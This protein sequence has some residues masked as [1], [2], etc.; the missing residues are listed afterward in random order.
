MMEFIRDYTYC[1]VCANRATAL[2]YVL[3]VLAL[4]LLPVPGH[5]WFLVLE[6]AF[7]LLGVTAFGLQTVSYYRRIRDLLSR[8]EGARSSKLT[9]SLKMR[10]AESSYCTRVAYRL[11]VNEH[12]KRVL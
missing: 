7:L 6:V 11:A 8:T 4:A 1:V 12:S 9:T 10:Y 5:L 2:G 3:L